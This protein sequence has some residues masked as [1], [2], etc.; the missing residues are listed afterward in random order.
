MVD[1]FNDHKYADILTKLSEEKLSFCSKFKE[2][3]GFDRGFYGKIGDKWIFAKLA[4]AENDFSL[5]EEYNNGLTMNSIRNEIPNLLYTY[6]VSRLKQCNFPTAKFSFPREVLFTEYINAKPMF[7]YTNKSSFELL[8]SWYQQ[9]V[10]VLNFCFGRTGLEH[11]DCHTFNIV[12]KNVEETVCIKYDDIKIYTNQIIILYDFGKSIFH[13]NKDLK[14]LINDL[15][16]SVKSI[17]RIKYKKELEILRNYISNWKDV[18]SFL[19]FCDEKWG[20]DIRR[21]DGKMLNMVYH[22]D[23]DSNYQNE[24][25]TIDIS[26]YHGYEEKIKNKHRRKENENVNDKGKMDY[27]INDKKYVA[28]KAPWISYKSN[29][30]SSFKELMNEDL[31]KLSKS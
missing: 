18:P 2:C 14:Y 24:E 25:I 20:I 9:L 19:D 6:S 15:I 10:I 13:K 4:K 11:R 29:I 27:L 21:G 7:Y 12:V 16:F 30:N 31:L 17:F 26:E 1:W 23:Y 22:I 28:P 3:R 5:I 8:L